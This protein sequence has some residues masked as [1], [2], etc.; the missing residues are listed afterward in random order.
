[1]S[2]G[3][4]EPPIYSQSF[5]ST[6]DNLD[7]PLITEVGG[8]A[9]V[10]NSLVGLNPQSEGPDAAPSRQRQGRGEFRTPSWYPEN[11]RTALCGE[12][13]ASSAKP[14]TD[15]QQSMR[16]QRTR[17][18]PKRVFSTAIAVTHSCH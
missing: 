15:A 3:S 5:R 8:E 7:F 1:M 18:F 6:G 11:Q 16:V 13:P 9:D 14:V 10:M 4:W 12:H 17:V 2:R